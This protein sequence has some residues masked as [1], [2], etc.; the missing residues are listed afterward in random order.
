VR[1]DEHEHRSAPDEQQ[2]AEV[3][4]AALGQHLALLAQVAREEDDQRELCEL[5]GLELERADVDPEAGAVDRLAEDGRGREREQQERAD[6]EEVLV[7]LEHAVVVAEGEHRPRE[8]A[9]AHDDPEALT[10]RVVRVQP[11]DQRQAD[12]GEERHHRQQVRVGVGHREARDHVRDDVE[13]EEEER[14]GQRAGRDLRLVRDVDAREADAGDQP[15]DDEIEE[16]AVPRGHSLM[17]MRAARPAPGRRRPR[18]GRRR[19]G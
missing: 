2:R 8:R 5:T 12:R 14:V 9:D 13:A 17:P 4:E 16:L 1:L 3:L 18:R 10:E 6:A 7:A 15:D 19:R 11:V